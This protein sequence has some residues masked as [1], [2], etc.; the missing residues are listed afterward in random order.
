MLYD[1]SITVFGIVFNARVEYNYNLGRPLNTNT[2]DKCDHLRPDDT[3]RHGGCN[4]FDVN[5]KS[6]T[7]TSQGSKYEKVNENRSQLNHTN[8]YASLESGKSDLGGLRG[9]SPPR[10]N[11]MP[12]GR[13]SPARKSQFF[14]TGRVGYLYI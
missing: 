6:A 4:T 13:R 2:F 9:G 1:S 3:P 8:S 11:P 14:E 5:Q 10:E 7:A 12:A